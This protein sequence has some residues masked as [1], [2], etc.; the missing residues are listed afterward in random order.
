MSD[1]ARQLSVRD[2]ARARRA[3]LDAIQGTVHGYEVEHEGRAIAARYR[4]AIAATIRERLGPD[5]TD[6]S[7]PVLNALNFYADLFVEFAV[8]GQA[9][10]MGRLALTLE[11]LRVMVHVGPQIAAH[12]EVWMRMEINAQR[13][14]VTDDTVQ[15]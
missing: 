1:E 3:L 9:V 6:G 13:P 11:A 14:A 5:P 4:P 12:V 2:E 7:V 8:D 10:P 15:A